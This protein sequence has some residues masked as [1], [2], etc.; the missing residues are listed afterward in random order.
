[1]KNLCDPIIYGDRRLHCALRPQLQLKQQQI[2]LQILHLIRPCVWQDIEHNDA[3]LQIEQLQAALRTPCQEEAAVDG[4]MRQGVRGAA[5]I[6]AEADGRENIT[7][8]IWV[9]TRD[10]AAMR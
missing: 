2:L 4:K 9:C 6:L 10:R 3:L 1:M 5:A 8:R 7:Q